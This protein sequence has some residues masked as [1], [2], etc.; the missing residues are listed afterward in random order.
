MDR[1]VRNL[2]QQKGSRVKVATKAPMPSE[3]EDGDIYLLGLGTNGTLFVKGFG[4]WW[5]FRSADVKGD[6]WHGST[7]RVKLLPADF[8]RVGTGDDTISISAITGHVARV[9]DDNDGAGIVVQKAIPLGYKAKGVKIYSNNDGDNDM[10]IKIHQF[11]MPDTDNIGPSPLAT[12]NSDT[13][14]PFESQKSS[15]DNYIHIQIDGLDETS[16]T[17]SRDKIYGG[18]IDISPVLTPEL[19]Q[20]GATSEDGLFRGG[21]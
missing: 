7:T 2:I 4:K 20:Q 14:I 5:A 9:G 16:A 6:G 21:D 19:I 10:I 1:E 12:G 13:Y 18:Y 3:G 15:S 8:R 17:G 11:N